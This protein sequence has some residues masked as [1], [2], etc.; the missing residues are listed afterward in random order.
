MDSMNEQ[1]MELFE[2]IRDQHSVC[3]RDLY[4]ALYWVAKHKGITLSNPY[5]PRSNETPHTKESVDLVYSRLIALP[6]DKVIRFYSILMHYV[7]L[8]FY[9]LPNSWAVP[10]MDKS[11]ALAHQ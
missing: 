4:A 2:E 1:A 11:I 8:K 7:F 9:S 6:S 10:V 5:V 3:Y